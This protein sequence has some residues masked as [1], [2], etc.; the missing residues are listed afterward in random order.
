MV[1]DVPVDFRAHGRFAKAFPLRFPMGIADLFDSRPYE[2]QPQEWLQHLLRFFWDGVWYEF[3]VLPFGLGT[4]PFVFT[5]LTYPVVAFLRALGIR[6]IIYLDDML[7]APIPLRTSRFGAPVCV[8]FTLPACIAF[9]VRLHK[10][11]HAAL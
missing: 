10:I 11:V 1:R 5:K 9:E 6:L 8:S 3:L 4:A 7:V 2:V